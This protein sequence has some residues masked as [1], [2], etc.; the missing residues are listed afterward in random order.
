VGNATEMEVVGF[1]Q[2]YWQS[3]ASERS[4]AFAGV[5]EGFA[6]CCP[7]ARSVSARA[8]LGGTSVTINNK[9]AYLWHAGTTQINLN[10][11]KVYSNDAQGGAHLI[12][13][14]RWRRGQQYSGAAAR[15]SFSATT[16]LHLGRVRSLVR[17]E[18]RRFT[19][20]EWAVHARVSIREDIAQVLQ[21]GIGELF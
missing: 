3:G 7:V 2:A 10:R 19:L 12:R 9:P 14:Y 4:S 20:R 13:T 8:S 15:I 16:P 6:G 21:I 1:P 11:I 5:L 17:L 18:R